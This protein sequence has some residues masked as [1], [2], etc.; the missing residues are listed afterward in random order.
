M[1]GVICWKSYKSDPKGIA[2]G[3]RQEKTLNALLKAYPDLK[4]CE[5]TSAYTAYYLAYAGVELLKADEKIVDMV[6]EWRQ[7]GRIDSPISNKRPTDKPKQH[8]PYAVPDWDTLL[9]RT[10]RA[11][12]LEMI[13]ISAIQQTSTPQRFKD[14]VDKYMKSV[15]R[16]TISVFDLQKLWQMF[17]KKLESE[18]KTLENA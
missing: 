10:D 4:P 16:N 1:F 5:L 2:R 3:G 8:D 9:A 6:R 15:L 13:H 18:G 17:L 12:D 11:R 7:K 14:G